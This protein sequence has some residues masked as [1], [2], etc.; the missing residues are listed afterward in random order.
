MF[1]DRLAALNLRSKRLHCQSEANL[2]QSTASF[3]GQS[4]KTF[5]S[6]S[7]PVVGLPRHSKRQ[8]LNRMR[9]APEQR[10]FE[11][12]LRDFY[13]VIRPTTRP[14]YSFSHPP[15]SLHSLTVMNRSTK[16]QVQGSVLAYQ[17]M[18]LEVETKLVTLV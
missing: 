5:A 15:P 13:F 17:G 11:S 1:L 12:A 10:Q 2:D 9:L 14:E 6:S 3:V 16:V 7:V 8:Y 4:L 18:V